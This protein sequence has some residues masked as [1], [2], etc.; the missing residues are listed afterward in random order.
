MC[1]EQVYDV[2]AAVD[3]AAHG[4]VLQSHTVTAIENAGFTSISTRHYMKNDD[5]FLTDIR[6]CTNTKQHFHTPDTI[7]PAS[8]PQFTVTDNYIRKL[9]TNQH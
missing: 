4:L 5:S 2:L 7:T 3:G 6:P 1:H 8:S 9:F